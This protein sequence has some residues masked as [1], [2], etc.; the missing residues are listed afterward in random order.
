MLNAAE[1]I[2]SDCTIVDFNGNK[3]DPGEITN[4]KN[5]LKNKIYT[6]FSGQ[7]LDRTIYVNVQDFN[8]VVP[9]ILATWEL[10]SNIF[11]HDLNY[12]FTRIPEFRDFYNFIDLS[13]TFDSKS[14]DQFD[15][16]TPVIDN[17]GYNKGTKYNSVFELNGNI[18]RT[19]VAVKT[20]TSGTTGRPRIIDFTHQHLI[21]RTKV[22]APYH[23]CG[24]ED[25]PFHLKTFHHGALFI[26][27]ALPMLSMAKEHHFISPANPLISGANYNAKT[28]L[29]LVLPHFQENGITAM[30]MPYEWINYFDQVDPV[31]LQDKVSIRTLRG[32]DVNTCN[33]IFEN[34][35]P[36]EIVNQFGCSELGTMF[37]SRV[38]QANYKEY[39]PRVFSE[40]AP[41]IEYV[42]E[43][44][45]VRARRT[46][47]DWHVLADGFVEDGD[48]L[49]YQGRS[50][51][52][53][54]NTGPVYI[55]D[56][57]NYLGT[58]YHMTKFQVVPDFLES[59]IYLAFFDETLDID[60]NKINDLISQN[61]SPR[62][63]VKDVRYFNLRD[64][65]VGIKPSGQI[66][67]Y[68][69]TKDQN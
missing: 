6:V 13:I 40:R 69:F 15:E 3:T 21:D 9:I 33:W 17:K 60:M 41:G 34:I 57:E 52:F 48:K 11:V 49:R 39:V 5:F 67:L 32:Y 23:N 8:W 53:A 68:A 44:N 56:L 38:T 37:I 18:Q 59:N 64:V 14:F 22:M 54:T 46:G 65:S 12:E 7:T 29:N 50:Y 28:F 63:C 58:I 4:R 51:S 55:Q 43:K 66:L 1:L 47:Y 36:K 45:L 61:V 27:Y 62:H 26:D 24:E 31:D 10:G 30:I 2:R 16:S 42:L 35:K 19:D 25:K 20:H